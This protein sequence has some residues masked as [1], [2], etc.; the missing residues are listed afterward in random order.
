VYGGRPVPFSG[1]VPPATTYVYDLNGTDDTPGN[2]DDHTC[3]TASNNGLGCHATG[4]PDWDPADN[5]GGVPLGCQNCH[6]DTTTSQV[7]PTTGLHDNLNLV[8]HDG[9]L[10]GGTGAACAK[11]HTASPTVVGSEHQNG[12]LQA[13]SA[14][15]YSWNT[16]NIAAGYNEA[17]DGCA[18]VCHTDST[19]GYWNRR[20]TGAV[21]TAWA[22]ANNAATATQCGNC[23]GS[24]QT[25]WNIVG[26]TSHANPDANN[27]PNTLGG[28]PARGS[29]TECTMCHGWGV[30]VYS[31]GT[32]HVNG[33]VTMNS[34]VTY[35]DVDGSC[36]INCHSAYLPD[37]LTMITASGWAVDAVAGGAPGCGSCHLDGVQ[38]GSE[39]PTHLAHGADH[40]EL[41]GGGTS[42][43]ACTGCHPDVDY[44]NAHGGAL[45]LVNVTYS[46]G[47]NGTC[48]TT[49]CHNN[50][51]N[52]GDVSGTWDT[53][54][55]ACNDCHYY[56]SGDPTSAANTGANW[57]LTGSH[58]AH[59][60]AAQ[61]SLCTNCHADNTADT[62]AP[63]THITAG[64]LVQRANAV[65]NNADVTAGGWNDTADTCTTAAC[66][67][68]SGTTY[69]SNAWGAA[70][71][72]CTMCHSATDPTTGDHTQHMGA[73]G[74]FGINTI[75]CVSCHP[76]QTDPA[77]A[78]NVKN[79]QVNVNGT[80]TTIGSPAIAGGC[81]TNDCH[82]DGIAG[83]PRD[84]TYLWGNAVTIANCDECHG[85]DAASQTNQAHGA[86]L[87]YTNALC[88]DC[89]T[90]ATAT[91]HINRTVNI[92]AA[93]ATYGGEVTVALPNSFGTCTTASCHN[94]SAASA[95]WDTAGQLSCTSCHGDATAGLGG[96]HS[97]HIAKGKTCADCHGSVTDTTHISTRPANLT[98]SANAASGEATVAMAAM[99][100]ATPNCTTATYALG[101]HAT[102]DPTDWGTP[103]AQACTAC[104][105]DT[106][107]SE[108]NPTTG[109]HDN[110]NLVD[111]DSTLSG[112][113]GAACEKCH[114]ASPTVVGS[115]HQNGTLQA[116][117]AGTYSWNTTNIAAGYNEAGDGCAAVCHTDS[118]HGYWNRRWTGAVDT[119][120]A[121]ANNAATATQCGNCHGSFQTNWN[122]VGETS[123][124][125][126]DANNDP[127]TL[128]GSPARGSHT[129]C[130]MCHGWG[131]AVY[132]TGTKH[133]NGSVTMNSDVT[134]LD[135]DGSC[136]IN[137]HSAY[138][139]DELT[140]ITASGWAV[141][142]VAGGAPG[143]GSCHLDGVQTG[144]ESPT[145]LAHGADHTELV[146][147]GTSWPA[148]TGCHPD[149]DYD[150]A[151][152]GALQ[153]VNVTY[154][155]GENGTCTTTS[156]HNNGAN[157]GDVSGTWDT[158][159]LACNDCHYYVSGD[160]TSAANTGANWALTGSHN[161]HFD[162]AQVSLC[163]NCHADNTADTTA[164]RT[165]ITAGTLVQRANAVANNAD[166]T[167]GGWNDTADTCTTAACH[168]PSGTTYVSNAWG[169]A[170]AGCTMCHSATDPTTGDHTQH[171]GAAGTFGINTI[172]CVSCHPNQTDPA[173]AN[174]V[175]NVQVNVNG[176]PTTIGSPAI[177]GGCGTND[178]HNDGIA[179][180]PRDATYL[181]GNAV[182]IAN[183]DECHGDDAASQ[184]NQA[185]GAHLGY[186]NALCTDCHT[187]ATAT[188]HINRTVNID[189]AKATYGG[190]VTVALPNSFG[191]CTTASCHNVSAASAAW[192][193]AGQLSCTSCHGDA[194]AGLG[195]SHSGHIAKGKTCADCH[196]SVTDTTHIST[197][198][199]NLTS[200]ANA[201]SGEATVAMAA[202]SFATPNCTT[203]TY[204]LGC[205]ATGDP[206]DWPGAAAQDCT[207]CHSDTTT[208]QVNPTSGLHGIVPKVS[209]QQH[210]Q[211]SRGCAALHT[212]LLAQST[213]A[214][215]AFSGG[216][217]ETPRSAGVDVHADRRQHGHLRDDELPSGLSDAWAHVWTNTAN[218]YTTEPSA[219]G[220]CH[221]VN[222]LAWNAGVLHKNTTKTE[223][224][225]GTGTNY[226]C[227]DCHT[228]EATAGNY[229]LVFDTEDWYP[230][231][232]TS[233]H[234]NGT[235]EVN[236]AGA[237]DG[238]TGDDGGTPGVGYCQTCHDAGR[239]PAG[240]I[241]DTAWPL[242]T[243][244]AGDTIDAGCGSCHGYPPV[245]SVSGKNGA[246]YTDAK[247]EDYQGGG[248]AHNVNGHVPFD[249][250]E[251][252]GMTPCA[253]CHDGGN[254]HNMTTPVSAN[255]GNVTVAIDS[256]DIPDGG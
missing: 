251:T 157:A 108:V 61:V 177:A 229:D 150:N 1:T 118:T 163:T 12:T 243:T 89:H 239:I 188:S 66:H 50:G 247:N 192:D 19:H 143:C 7:N 116:T 178:C 176:T 9:T 174:N 123:H 36:S 35:L 129:E 120:W 23:H 172:T 69:V 17:G 117:S 149:V 2:V 38:T 227:K 198:P 95:A 244:I 225:H 240:V 39:S 81:G 59:F 139:P 3:G 166:V 76:N 155:G 180:A 161:A 91:S 106:T 203:A 60:D 88:T 148:C 26:E 189:A 115:E 154:S 5:A 218:Y 158:G 109:L 237:Y 152:G 93:K 256:A 167:A 64:T 185:H 187:G 250:D 125:N 196:G 101:C 248:G 27:D 173:H 80:P 98:S 193:T 45:Q 223:S 11:C 31:T 205:H 44:D 41:V 126:P 235:I 136:S 153:L 124:A 169:A 212:T 121:Y 162:A 144:S 84:A 147:G 62:T 77:H 208:T 238:A 220:G 63:R 16:T 197:R 133:V 78:N 103:V 142:A 201:A 132:S 217:G 207:A 79:V 46:G 99:S 160:P 254:S 85:D 135:V 222:I 184:T 96:S 8:D 181:W 54:N 87:G 119:A 58:N 213:H 245:Q 112:G 113:T 70:N 52:A 171:M 111:H 200:S 130:T 202:M 65:A 30:A 226:Q 127:N 22:Y 190:E 33:S 228:F 146:G 164:P 241:A 128:G 231:N 92:D 110:L 34:D 86:H 122:I 18:A 29:H 183:C 25:N 82:N 182:T 20:W 219:C 224:T 94:V 75:T 28:S 252:A 210:N 67:N 179:G 242:N 43:P 137:C 90:G 105:S 40:T 186:T 141:D 230:L 57:A 102:G 32:K 199:A 107:T 206:T 246:R 209:G 49:S 211:A 159:N 214:N 100:F 138:L 71:A 253:K 15:T 10:S 131:V 42:W 236:N 13:T 175:K 14:G 194:T 51:A 37:E 151:H 48:T 97:G 195:G 68:P 6:T 73:A 140:M 204:A 21:D 255:V 56:V 4:A 74:T 104:H 234:G 249:I 233:E 191:T 221:G 156:C 55:L 170:N 134:Y 232:N 165:H 215:G 145:H 53:G 83:A 72:G 168:N 114:T 47:E 216:S 24:F